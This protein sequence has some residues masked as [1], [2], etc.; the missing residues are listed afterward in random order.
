VREATKQLLK[1]NKALKAALKRCKQKL[2][3]S[4]F[5]IKNLVDK[6]NKNRN[7]NGEMLDSCVEDDEE[8]EAKLVKKLGQLLANHCSKTEKAE[9]S[10]TS[11]LNNLK[12]S[13]PRNL[14][15][16]EVRQI[17]LPHKIGECDHGRS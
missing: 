2:S 7:D 11:I 9:K 16:D 1:E 8:L 4:E 17:F 6:I 5:M 3:K 13:M 14:V 12:V 15:R 10:I